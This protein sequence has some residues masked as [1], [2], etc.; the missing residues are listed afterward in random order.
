MSMI[1]CKECG[2]EISD[3]ANA[4]PHCGC[5]ITEDKEFESIDKLHREN[6]L[7]LLEITTKHPSNKRNEMIK[8]L[9]EKTGLTLQQAERV[10]NTYLTENKNLLNLPKD[11]FDKLFA[12]KKDSALSIWAA[13]L[14]LF[15]YTCWLGGILAIIDFLKRDKT[16]RHIGSGFALFMCVA[17]LAVCSTKDS[18]ES[19][20]KNGNVKEV[21]NVE[22][23]KPETQEK[24]QETPSEITVGN[25]FEANGLKVTLNDANTDFTDYDDEYGVYKP[26]D[27]YKYIS[28]SFTFEN[29]GDSDR[30]VSI[31]D[32][33]CYADGTLCEQSY[34]FGGDFIN[35]NISSGRNV[36]FDTYYVVPVESNSIELEYTSNIWT[37]EKVIIK[38]K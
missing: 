18:N 10:I 17:Q 22:S 7:L 34:N 37:D 24:P 14:G 30:Y 1:I 6:N 23:T 26:E 38:I 15:T 5:P 16:K 31:Y 28:A 9:R 12:K 3:K 20:T 13:V 21:V 8:E 27:G 25:S 11:E 36:S 33:D 29:T 35:A 4:C 2:K 32:F 19:N